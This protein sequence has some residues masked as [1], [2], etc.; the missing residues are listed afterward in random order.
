M[1]GSGDTG[2]TVHVT[3][4]LVDIDDALL[5]SARTA[6]GTLTMKDTVNAALQAAADL[7]HR[8]AHLD[9]LQAHGLPD[10]GDP[11]VRADAWR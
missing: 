3:K 7:A 1:S 2:Y 5:Q 10:L 4:R 11:Q 8:R 9:R 6:L